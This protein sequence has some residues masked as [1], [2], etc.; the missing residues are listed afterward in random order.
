MVVCFFLKKAHA[1]TKF[2]CN[3]AIAEWTTEA[4]VIVYDA[5]RRVLVPVSAACRRQCWN[6]S[7]AMAIQYC[8]R[9]RTGKHCL[10]N[11]RNE[12]QCGSKRDVVEDLSI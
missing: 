11:N 3:C 10:N 5:I 7:G 9:S 2:T 6:H 4:V 8:C 1:V 12:P